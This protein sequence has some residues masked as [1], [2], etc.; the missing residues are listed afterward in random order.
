MKRVSAQN[1]MRY[2]DDSERMS[3]EKQFFEDLTTS[4]IEVVLPPPP[5]GFSWV[6]EAGKKKVKISGKILSTDVEAATSTY[7]FA[8]EGGKKYKLA[9]PFEASELLAALPDVGE[10]GCDDLW[11]QLVY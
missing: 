11:R 5:L 7:E 2:L 8:V 6:F 9:T 4:S 10:T 3:A 1:Q